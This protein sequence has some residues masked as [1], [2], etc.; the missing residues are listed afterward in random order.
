[1]ARSMKYRENTLAFVYG[2]FAALAAGTAAAIFYDAHFQGAK[3]SL[4]QMA[5]L[6]VCVLLMG[7]FL[8]RAFQQAFFSGISGFLVVVVGI[9]AVAG[10]LFLPGMLGRGPGDSAAMV[11]Q[12]VAAGTATLAYGSP[13]ASE[14]VPTD[15]CRLWSDVGV[16]MVGQE[17][18]VYGDVAQAYS[19]EGVAF[20]VFTNEPGHFF[21][22]AYNWGDASLAGQCVRTTG[23]VQRLGISPVMV[24]AQQADIEKC[25]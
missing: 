4:V 12:P 10:V 5:G 17:M 13:T 15:A 8:F 11:G 19:K 23:V 24:V 16:E 21:L 22:L 6:G 7:F 18:C 9:L 20:M 2:L 25:R 1:M 3:L 14:T